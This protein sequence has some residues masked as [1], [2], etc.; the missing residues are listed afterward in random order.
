M[1][2]FLLPKLLCSELEGIILDFGGRKVMV[3]R[4]FI[5][6]NGQGYVSLKRM[7]TWVFDALLCLILLC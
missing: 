5:G 3:E 4:A 1:S 7:V 2:C 6:V